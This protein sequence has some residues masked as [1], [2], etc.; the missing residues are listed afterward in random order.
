MCWKFVAAIGV[1]LASAMPRAQTPLQSAASAAPAF[2]IDSSLE[3]FQL[4]VA[5]D[6]PLV[7]GDSA[8]ADNSAPRFDVQGTVPEGST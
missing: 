1:V 3:R 6:T 5:A 2:E 8:L 7:H 4:V